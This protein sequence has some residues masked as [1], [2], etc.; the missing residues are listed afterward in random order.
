MTDLDAMLIVF[1]DVFEAYLAA[2]PGPPWCLRLMNRSRRR[3]W[4]D[5]CGCRAL[6]RCMTRAA[7]PLKRGSCT[8]YCGPQ[9]LAFPRRWSRWRLLPRPSCRRRDNAHRQEGRIIV[10]RLRP[11]SRNLARERM[12][13]GSYSASERCRRVGQT[14]QWGRRGV[15]GI[16]PG[17]SLFFDSMVSRH[18]VGRRAPGCEA[19]RSR[20]PA[21]LSR[22]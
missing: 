6:P 15:T 7:S 14:W 20:P 13:A 1:P 17:H 19:S 22:M 12:I 18:L 10:N 21:G 3:C 5:C 8:R 16:H 4:K 11:G 2:Y 9:P